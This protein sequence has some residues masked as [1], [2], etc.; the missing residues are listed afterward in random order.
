MYFL[1]RLL[2]DNGETPGGAASAFC[3]AVT[4]MSTFHLSTGSSSPPSIETA[5]AMKY[6]PFL[7]ASCPSLSMYRIVV[8]VDVSL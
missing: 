7:Y 4:Q 1:A 2:T 5:S 8:P 3:D 6:A